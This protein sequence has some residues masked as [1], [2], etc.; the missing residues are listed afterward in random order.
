MKHEPLQDHS[1]AITRG[2]TG[3]FFPLVLTRD[4]FRVA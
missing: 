1:R 4:V 3:V 2:A